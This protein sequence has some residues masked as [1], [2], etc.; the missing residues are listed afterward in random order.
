MTH[1]DVC[2]FVS[3]ADRPNSGDS[4]PS[5]A[6]PLHRLTS[7]PDAARELSRMPHTYIHVLPSLYVNFMNANDIYAALS[8]ILT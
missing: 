7:S 6:R 1:V 5:T 4:N 2:V 3:F 8:R